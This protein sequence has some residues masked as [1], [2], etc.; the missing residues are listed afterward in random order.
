MQIGDYQLLAELGRGATSV[1]YQASSPRFSQPV[2]LKVVNF[3]ASATPEQRNRLL[4][5]LKREAQVAAA[6]NH[7]NIVRPLEVGRADNEFFLA[8][9]LVPGSS[10][11]RRVQMEGPVALPDLL[12]L[13]DQVCAALEAAHARGLLHL[14]IKPDNIL[15]AANGAAKLTDFGMVAAASEALTAPGSPA[16]MSPEQ[17]AKAAL[18]ARS[19]I[20][21]LAATL[22][23]AATGRRAFPGEDLT[24]VAH[25]V[26]AVEPDYSALPPAL[27]AVLRLAMS[28]DPS[29]RYRSVAELRAALQDAAGQLGIVMAAVPPP[30][31]S[32]ASQWSAAAIGS[33]A[34]AL[35]AFLFDPVRL[36]SLAAIVFAGSYFW[37]GERRSRSSDWLAAAGALLALTRLVLGCAGILDG[38]G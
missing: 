38:G 18:D 30:Q 22:Y 1:V 23:E 4:A 29:Y 21:S 27:A 15:V 11:R 7:P 34:L 28:K 19:D 25:Q 24:T 12:Y 36:V 31:V 32:R 14:D 5:S 2:A 17:V 37:G 16:Y 20:F 26:T 6:L 33:A 35:V 10:L 9:E 13:A 3:P 8:M